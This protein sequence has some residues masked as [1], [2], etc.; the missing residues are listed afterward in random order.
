MPIIIKSKVIKGEGVG[1]SVG[2]KTANLDVQNLE[3]SGLKEFGV[4]VCKV[5][6][7]EKFYKGLL[8]YGPKKTFNNNIS[9]EVLI[10]DF[11]QDIY[12][13]ELEI[14]VFNKIRD[15]KKFASKKKLIEQIKQDIKKEK[16]P[17]LH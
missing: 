10:I 7:K 15:I 11:N 9:A 13:K 12:G 1:K 16:S 4:Y 3:K 5:K 2:L 17:C 8:H 6:Y 14:E